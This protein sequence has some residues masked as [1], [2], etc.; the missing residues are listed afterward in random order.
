MIKFIS[1][2]A[3]LHAWKLQIYRCFCP[4]VA[5]WMGVLRHE[6]MTTFVK[7]RGEKYMF[8]LRNDSIHH[9]RKSIPIHNTYIDIFTYIYTHILYMPWEPTTFLHF[10]GGVFNSY[11]EGLKPSFFMGFG[12]QRCIVMGNTSQDAHIVASS[13]VYSWI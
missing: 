2:E 6:M 5:T 10:W 11:F 3:T 9:G 7:Y 13:K 4:F 8:N 1:L 12:V